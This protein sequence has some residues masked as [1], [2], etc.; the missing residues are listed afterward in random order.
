[1]HLA[2]DHEADIGQMMMEREAAKAEARDL[3]SKVKTLQ[4]KLDEERGRA[5]TLNSERPTAAGTTRRPAIVLVVHRDA[6]TRAMTKH[7]LELSGYSVA[8]AADG[9]EGLRVAASQSPDVVLAE[10]VMPKMNGRELVQLLKA[11]PETA[12]IKVVL[13][14]AHAADRERGDFRADDVLQSPSDFDA[15]R[16]TLASVLAK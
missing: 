1:M 15:M 6:G 16:A 13:I 7:A 5:A 10:A 2:S 14:S 9:L 8:T 4:K 11:R 3:A 12:R